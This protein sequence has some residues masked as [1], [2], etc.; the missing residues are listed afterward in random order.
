MNNAKKPADYPALDENQIEELLSN[1]Q[2][3]PGKAFIQKMQDTPWKAVQTR[4][5]IS[6]KTKFAL[7]TLAILLVFAATLIFVPPVRA[8]VSEWFSVVFHDPNNRGSF[9]VSGSEPMA[10]QVM[11][12]GYLPLILSE[13]TTHAW[14][15]KTSEVVYKVDDK[16]LII[17]QT[18]A[19]DG[20]SLPEGEAAMVNG[21]PAILNKGLSGTYR[22]EPEGILTPIAASGTDQEAPEG[23]THGGGIVTDQGN[24]TPQSITVG[25]GPADDFITFDYTDVAKLTFMI[26]NTKIEMLSNMDVDELIKIAESLV[27]AM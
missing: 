25:Q 27:P 1:I 26:G 5:K 15:G 3:V 13:G 7:S 16:F 17:T 20:E 9:G 12:P 24:G 18:A 22:E 10:Y 19:V 14:F 8:Q 4:G 11:Q 6:M 21:H 23:A 2:P